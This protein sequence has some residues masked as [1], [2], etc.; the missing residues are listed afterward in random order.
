MKT[1]NSVSRKILILQKI[2]KK[3]DYIFKKKCQASEK[4]VN[5]YALNTWLGLLL[6]EL[7]HQC[8]V[9]WMKSACDTAPVYWKPRLLL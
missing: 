1:P 4:Y 8:G 9:A 7:L 6:H 3:K 5:F 2:K